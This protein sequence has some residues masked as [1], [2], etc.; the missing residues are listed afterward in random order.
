V[1]G[2]PGLKTLE[3]GLAGRPT[4]GGPGGRRASFRGKRSP[5]GCACAARKGPVAGTGW[6][7]DQ[8][9]KSSRRRGRRGSSS[10]PGLPRSARQFVPDARIRYR[11]DREHLIAPGPKREGQVVPPRKTTW[12]A[13]RGDPLRLRYTSPP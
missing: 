9:T 6:E 8:K 13:C 5:R 10:P 12:P 4:Q 7:L 3:A 11:N 1:I 2:A